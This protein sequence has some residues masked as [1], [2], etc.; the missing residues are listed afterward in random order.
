M[1]IEKTPLGK[2]KSENTHRKIQAEQIPLTKYKPEST[3]RKIQ[4]GQ[5]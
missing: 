1:P 3:T 5:V 4:F 2:C